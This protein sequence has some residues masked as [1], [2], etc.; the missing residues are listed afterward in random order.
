LI[1]TSNILGGEGGGNKTFEDI[2]GITVNKEGD[3]YAADSKL[4]CIKKFKLN[5]DYVS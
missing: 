4:H 5:G 1:K 3:L 2:T